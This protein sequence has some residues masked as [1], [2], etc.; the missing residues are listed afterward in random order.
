MI[1]ED[2]LIRALKKAAVF[3]DLDPSLLPV[4]VRLENELEAFRTKESAL[5]RAKALAE[6]GAEK[7]AHKASGLS[8]LAV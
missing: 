6:S 3:V 7:I 2:R 5:N 4:Y 8:N 1:T